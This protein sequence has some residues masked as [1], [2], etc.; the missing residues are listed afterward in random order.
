MADSPS[1]PPHPACPA[2]RERTVRVTLGR[3]RRGPDIGG[4]RRQTAARLG[5]PQPGSRGALVR[6]SERPNEQTHPYEAY[7]ITECTLNTYDWSGQADLPW[8][9]LGDRKEAR[10]PVTS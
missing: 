8:A 7:P 5:N 3:Y 9:S 10:L 1:G 4:S 2:E 6:P